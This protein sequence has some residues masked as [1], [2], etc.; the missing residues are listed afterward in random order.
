MILALDSVTVGADIRHVSTKNY[1][2]IGRTFEF[3]MSWK[4]RG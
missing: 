1:Q 4:T 3:F 2:Q